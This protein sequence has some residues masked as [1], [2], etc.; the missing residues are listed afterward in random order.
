MEFVWEDQ[1]L[2]T[3]GALS[4]IER[5]NT[6]HI[7]L[8]NSDLFTDVDFEDLYLSTIQHNAA[9]GVA[10]VP[11]TTKVPY[12]IF[13]IEENKITGLKE[14]PVYTNYANAGIYI[15]NTT[16][17]NKIPRNTFYNITDLMEQLITE[18]QP[19]IHNPIVGY[20][21]DIGQHQD[22]IN[23]QEIV[24]HLKNGN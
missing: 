7:L 5:F 23:A 16:V 13:N 4:L 9:M 2:G 8:M 11:Y 10:T 18:N 14:K 12:G 3:A 15:L 21:I 1:P 20:W 17:L 22:Y 19:I 24:K 6:N